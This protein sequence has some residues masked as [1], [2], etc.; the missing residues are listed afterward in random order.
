MIKKIAGIILVASLVYGGVVIIKGITEK[1]VAGVV[2]PGTGGHLVDPGT[3]GHVAA[4][5]IA[6]TGSV[7]PGTGGH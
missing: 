6:P 1:N 3:G 2:D 4:I 5:T 7:D